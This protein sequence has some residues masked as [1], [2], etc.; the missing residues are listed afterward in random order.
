[1][2]KLA[3]SWLHW[4][5]CPWPAVLVST[6]SILTKSY[7][8]KPHRKSPCQSPPTLTQLMW[9]QV[10]PVVRKK[11]CLLLVTLPDVFLPT[12]LRLWSDGCWVVPK[13]PMQRRVTTQRNVTKICALRQNTKCHHIWQEYR[14]TWPPNASLSSKKIL[15]SIVCAGIS[16]ES[17]EFTDNPTWRLATSN[18]ATWKALPL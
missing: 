7:P 6:K 8:D 10:G 4:V 1:M 15:W 17:S 3:V 9:S 14:E 16:A 5:T 18:K 12:D 13:L 2:R 11:P